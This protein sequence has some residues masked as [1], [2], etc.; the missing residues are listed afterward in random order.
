MKKCTSF[1]ENGFSFE[2]AVAKN[3]LASRKSALIPII[4][5]GWEEGKCL[6]EEI[7]GRECTFSRPVAKNCDLYT[8]PE[9]VHLLPED[10]FFLQQTPEPVSKVYVLFKKN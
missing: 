2:S 6:W 10:F 9:K 7:V 1:P 4:K 5:F 8:F 3:V